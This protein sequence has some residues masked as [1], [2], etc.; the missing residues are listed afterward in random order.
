MSTSYSA[1]H[2]ENSIISLRNNDRTIDSYSRHDNDL[3]PSYDEDGFFI[4]NCCPVESLWRMPS[5]NFP[6]IWK[7]DFKEYSLSKSDFG[8][9]TKE[10]MHNDLS[11]FEA[12][13]ALEL[14]RWFQSGFDFCN[15]YLTWYDSGIGNSW[16]YQTTSGTIL[17]V[18]LEGF[19]VY[20][21]NHRIGGTTDSLLQSYNILQDETLEDAAVEKTVSTRYGSKFHKTSHQRALRCKNRTRVRTN[22]RN[23]K[24][25]LLELV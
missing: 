19:Y 1:V 7:P 25:S 4:D 20:I 14:S 12:I 3:I 18:D 11:T 17:V 16:Y 5:I 2:I 22:H 6:R 23:A 15:S 8:H 24:Y 21:P 13:V 10:L 9:F